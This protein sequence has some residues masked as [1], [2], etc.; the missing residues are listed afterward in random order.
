MKEGPTSSAILKVKTFVQPSR[1]HRYSLCINPWHMFGCTRLEACKDARKFN[2]TK[3]T[4]LREICCSIYA[5]S[6]ERP[7][8]HNSKYNS[9][10]WFQFL[11]VSR[12]CI[13]L[14]HALKY[15]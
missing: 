12:P 8:F 2:K 15:V 10:S 1:N 3:V 9:K 14:L 7:A 13:D 6:F 4:F 11:I 5:F